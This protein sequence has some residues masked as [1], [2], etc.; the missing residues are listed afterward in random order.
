MDLHRAGKVPDWEK[1]EPEDRNI[2]QRVAAK[3]G[4]VATAANVITVGGAG[5]F[6]DGLYDYTQGNKPVGFFKMLAGGFAD[7]ADGFVANITK[8]KSSL[9]EALDASLDKAKKAAA[10]IALTATGVIP[11]V[12][13][14]VVGGQQTANVIATGIA[15]KRGNEIHPEQANKINELMQGCILGAFVVADMISPGTGQQFI[16]HAAEIG[17]VAGTVVIGGEGTIELFDQALKP[18]QTDEAV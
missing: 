11:I 6:L 4:G 18:Q 3:T 7:A 2:F 10:L 13:A 17:S 9:G 5:L 14:L 8:T 1:V 16:Y 15:K 12:P